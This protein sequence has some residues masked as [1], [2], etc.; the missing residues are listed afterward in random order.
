MNWANN[1]IRRTAGKRRKI[2]WLGI[3]VCAL[4]RFGVPS[5][6]GGGTHRSLTHA[7]TFHFTFFLFFYIHILSIWFEADDFHGI[8]TY[9]PNFW[10]TKR[11]KTNWKWSIWRQNTLKKTKSCTYNR[12]FGGVFLGPELV[13]VCFFISLL[14]LLCPRVKWTRL[15]NMETR[16]WSS[17]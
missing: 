11:K 15:H 5:I 9:S 13:V 16:S 10:W 3:C 8:S 7:R 14:L 4:H 1:I 2:K 17:R 6:G 12:C